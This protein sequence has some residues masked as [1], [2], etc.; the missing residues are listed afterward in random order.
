MKKILLLTAIAFA[1]T[2]SAQ[3]KLVCGNNTIEV[4]GT[5]L[6][7]VKYI[8]SDKKDNVVTSFYTL[9]ENNTLTIW[10]ENIDNGERQSV[11]VYTV[12][13]KDIDVFERKQPYLDEVTLSDYEKP[14]KRI[15]ITCASNVDCVKSVSYFSWFA[16]GKTDDTVNRFL[17]IDGTDKAVHQKF[18]DQLLSWV[19][20]N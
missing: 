15:Y 14:T 10:E 17:Q 16:Q 19:K 8:G 18:L 13:K 1:T 9:F 12:N 2:V 11:V 5:L 7:S 6:S 20:T 3:T 4:K